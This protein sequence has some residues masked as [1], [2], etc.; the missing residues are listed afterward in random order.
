[1]R[2]AFDDS[3]EREGD[4]GLPDVDVD[5]YRYTAPDEARE[6]LPIP[7]SSVSAL[8]GVADWIESLGYT[9]NTRFADALPATRAL[10][11]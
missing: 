7:P 9:I 1:M 11:G 2:A 10:T 4:P 5:A 8:W 3:V 6:A